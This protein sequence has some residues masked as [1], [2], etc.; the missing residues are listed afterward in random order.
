M[1]NFFFSFCPINLCPR[2]SIV[3]NFCFFKWVIPYIA[4]NVCKFQSICFEFFQKNFLTCLSVIDN[5]NNILID[6]QG[7]QISTA[8]KITFDASLMLWDYEKKTL[9]SIVLFLLRLNC[10]KKEAKIAFMHWNFLTMCNFIC[11]HHLNKRITT[12]TITIT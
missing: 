7:V 6:H 11:F 9:L 1:I 8:H 2:Y 5:N 4:V 10:Y 3:Q 12:T